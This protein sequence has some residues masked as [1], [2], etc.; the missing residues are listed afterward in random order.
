VNVQVQFVFLEIFKKLLEL[1]SCFSPKRNIYKTQGETVW[2]RQPRARE[3][4]MRGKHSEDFTFRKSSQSTSV[5]PASHGCRNSLTEPHLRGLAFVPLS[6]SAALTFW[7]PCKAVMTSP[8]DLDPCRAH[9]GGAA[10]L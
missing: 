9:T 5:P 7:C 4:K 8:K 6:S 10:V 3:F 1:D 2:R